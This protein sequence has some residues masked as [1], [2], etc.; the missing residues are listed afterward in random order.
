MTRG[1]LITG[2]TGGL[3][4]EFAH[5]YGRQ[6]K[7]L[8]LVA[9]NEKALEALAEEMKNIYHIEVLGIIQDL[10]EA[11]A[12]SHISVKLKEANWQ[13]EGL[14][15]NAG[16]G[17]FGRFHELA[18][19]RQ[20]ELVQ[21][22]VMA[23]MQL[24]HLVLDDMIKENKG[25]II[26]VASLAAFVPGPLMAPY[27]ASKAFVLS[28]TEGIARELKGS[29]VKILALCPGPTETGF[30]KNA[31][32]ENSKLFSSLK[33]VPA[34]YVVEQGCKALEKGKVIHVIGSFNR[35][36]V[37]ISRFAPRRVI[38]NFIYHVQEEK[39]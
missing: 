28:L 38:R 5:Y 35:M 25:F 18:I 16:F 19:A 15:N 1:V 2:A 7:N 24:T 9:R 36:L 11:E 30:E 4:K 20:T 32:L 23:M 13:V 12:V 31:R 22:N 3:G 26:N 10:T 37:F 17:D 29:K 34:K 8:I 21:V 27:Y 6:K 33:V 14:V 39:K